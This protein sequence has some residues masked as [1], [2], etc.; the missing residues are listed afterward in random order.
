[1]KKS[2]LLIALVLLL[3]GVVSSAGV[4]RIPS[5]TAEAHMMLPVAGGGTPGVS[6][7]ST[8]II[9]DFDRASIG[10]DWTDVA[11]GI[12]ISSNEAAGSTAD[13][14]NSAY[15]NASSYADGYEV[16]ITLT[17][18]VNDTSLYHLNG[19]YNGYG[20]LASPAGET[21]EIQE[22]ASGS[23]TTLGA[24]ISQTL[25]N[26]DAVGLKKDGSTLTAYYKASGGS[27]AEIGNRT[28]STYSVTGNFFL[29]IYSTTGRCDDFGGGNP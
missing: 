17:T 13:A 2:Y 25:S 16:Y 24:A 10:S 11:N 21:I 22:I 26:G 7:P 1:M 29:Q 15:Y 6:F 4:W 5:G 20:L 23:P 28:D 3:I 14:N 27:W 19:S 12:T 9:D 18:A 8:S